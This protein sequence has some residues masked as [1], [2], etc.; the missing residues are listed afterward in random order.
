MCITFFHRD[1][2]ASIKN[3]SCAHDDG[4]EDNDDALHMLQNVSH[5]FTQG[6]SL[7]VSRIILVQMRMVVKIV[8]SHVSSSHRD[9]VINNGKINM[10]SWQTFPSQNLLSPGV[11]L[12]RFISKSIGLAVA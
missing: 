1:H 3:Y 7:L 5:V 4:G 11:T 2:K 8:I 12:I 9:L 10:L 6:S